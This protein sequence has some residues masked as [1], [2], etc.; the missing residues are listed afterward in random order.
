MV[1]I[2]R[3]R[4][5]TWEKVLASI[6]PRSMV[7]ILP[8]GRMKRA[9]GRDS[10]GRLLRVRSGIADVLRTID[11][12]QML[13]AYSQGLHH[14]Q[15]PDQGAPPKLFETVRMRLES[16]DIETYRAALLERGDDF[17]RA[18][19]EDLTRRRDHFC[20]SDTGARDEVITPTAAAAA[21][22]G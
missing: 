15:I 19:I 4:D 12:G 10:H 16:L 1:S 3:E 2:T 18:V 22:G 21:A 7:I 13:L 6:D 11:G 8:E 9:N 20:T 5:Q 17:Q 14:V